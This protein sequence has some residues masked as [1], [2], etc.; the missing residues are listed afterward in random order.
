MSA[1]ILPFTSAYPSPP[2]SL[3]AGGKAIWVKGTDLWNTGILTDRDLDA[4]QMYCEAF[5]EI[6]HCDSVVERDGEY[7]L[8]S[9]GTYSE[10]PALR[11]RRAAEQKLLRYQK[12]FGLVPDARKKK[13]TVQQG[14]ASRKR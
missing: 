7:T 1:E 6:T 14:V 3:K 9:Q 12:I 8:S 2:K 4:W 11:R 5:D 10:H 13:P